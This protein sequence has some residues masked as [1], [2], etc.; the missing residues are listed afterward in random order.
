MT[1]KDSKVSRRDLL[2]SATIAGAGLGLTGINATTPAESFIGSPEFTGPAPAG[3][4]VIGMPFEKKD[5]VRLGIIGVGARGSGMLGNWLAVDNVQVTAICDID[6]NQVAKAVRQIEKAGQKAPATYSK[7][8]RDFENLCKRDDVDFIYIATPWE[9]H[10]PMAVA[11]MNNGKHVGTEV[12]AITTLKESWELVDTSEKTRRHCVIMENC[13]YGWSEMM[14]L[15]MVKAGMFGELLHGEAAYN[16]DLRGIVN[17]NRSEGLWRRNWHTKLNGN[18]YPTHGL[19]PVSNYLGV[20]RGDRF[21]YIVSMSSP[22]VGLY[23][24]REK[25]VPKDSPKWKEKYVCGDVNT[26]LIRTAKGRTI[27]LQHNVST[28][29]PYD[30]INQIQGTKGIFRDYPARIFFDG[31]GGEEQFVALDKFKERYEHSLWKDVGELARKKGGHGG[32]DYIMVWRLIQ[33]MREG[34]VPDMDVYD[35]AAWSVPFPL[36]AMSVEQGSAPVKFPDFTR[37]RW[38]DARGIMA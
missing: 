32:M 19:G 11:G 34:L 28:P 10:V 31:Q 36:S 15:N 3:G 20:N 9:W 4:S 12:P 13:C 37:G 38:K 21:D 33:C 27:M 8:D 1:R 6:K 24:Y 16:H 17:E 7:N 35:A 18:L 26:S 5:I 14:V 23:E 30:R 29:R 25:T 22:S 2:K